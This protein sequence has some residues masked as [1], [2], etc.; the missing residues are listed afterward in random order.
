MFQVSNDLV[1]KIEL[2]LTEEGIIDDKGVERQKPRHGS[3]CTCQDCGF[4]HDDCRCQ[5][6]DHNTVWPKLRADLVA[7]SGEVERLREAIEIAA[8]TCSDVTRLGRFAA[9]VDPVRWVEQVKAHLE[10][11][12]TAS[13]PSE[14][15]A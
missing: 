14:D 5:L 6:N 7:L 8:N 2:W 15:P 12:L 11:A 13:S 1:A 3:C 9:S 4:H 10:A